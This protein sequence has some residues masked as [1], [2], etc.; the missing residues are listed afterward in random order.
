MKHDVGVVILSAGK[1]ERMGQPKALLQFDDRRRFIDKILEEYLDFGC[2]NIV[3]VVNES[4][5]DYINNKGD[6]K[7]V[8]N[9]R[10][11]CGRFYSMKLGMQN[12]GDMNCCFIQNIDN[13]FV[14]KDILN[15]L[16]SRRDTNLYIVPSY[17]GKGGHPILIG[18]KIIDEIKEESV[19][20]LNLKDYLKR[21]D[22][23]FVDTEDDKILLNIN[24]PEDYE[25][26][27]KHG[28]IRK[29]S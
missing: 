9:K 4:G 25:K 13:P 21:F 2:G 8:I 6:I 12:I 17:R 11:E 23:K 7:I 27:I 15:L 1:S 28:L 14:N 3:A 22:R 26:N 24:T 19:N 5:I 18:R 29:N 20:D 10:L 16:Y